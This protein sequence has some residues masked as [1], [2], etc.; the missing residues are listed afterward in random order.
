M[1]MQREPLSI[2]NLRAFKA[3]VVEKTA[4]VDDFIVTNGDKLN[5]EVKINK[6]TDDKDE[7]GMLS[8]SFQVL[9]RSIIQ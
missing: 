1:F 4:P 6:V 8:L 3:L 7:Q 5:P 9:R 2:R